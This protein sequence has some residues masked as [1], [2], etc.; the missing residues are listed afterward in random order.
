MNNKTKVIFTTSDLSEVR[1]KIKAFETLY[2]V[3]PDVYVSGEV[4]SFKD[5]DGNYVSDID[6]AILF[7][8]AGT[9]YWTEVK[10]VRY[11]YFSAMYDGTLDEK[12]MPSSPDRLEEMYTFKYDTNSYW[13]ENMADEEEKERIESND[14]EEDVSDTKWKLEARI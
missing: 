12:M 1:E 6:D 2:G 3:S 5:M 14:P 8:L 10:S 13:Y 7:E 9:S 4:I 11:K